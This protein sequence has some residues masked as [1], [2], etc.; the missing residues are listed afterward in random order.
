METDL[1]LS[2]QGLLTAVK[3]LLT[4]RQTATRQSLARW[5]NQLNLKDSPYTMTDAQA[6]AHYADLLSLRV[7]PAKAKQ[8]TIEYIRSNRC[9]QTKH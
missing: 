9:P 3:G 8:L 1:Y 7:K 4:Y 2:P 5:R 6:I